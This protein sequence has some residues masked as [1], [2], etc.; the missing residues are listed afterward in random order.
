M[1]LPPPKIAK[2]VALP[3]R[4]AIGLEAH[5]VAVLAKHVKAIA[6]DGRCA[7]RSWSA[8]V[9]L[10]CPHRL[11]PDFLPIRTIERHDH[12]VAAAGA[13]ETLV[14]EG[15]PVE[16][17]RVAIQTL[18]VELDPLV[19]RL[20]IALQENAPE[21]VALPV[22]V[23]EVDPVQSREIGVQLLTLLA[24]FD[25]GAVDFIEANRAAL[26]PLFDDGAWLTFEKLV[27]DYAFAE[28]QAGL[29]R[30]LSGEGKPG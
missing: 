9:R 15:A 11:R 25:P 23:S 18:A 4:G 5:Q 2:D 19:A 1:Q 20:K 29:E 17:I 10:R 6:V 13:L 30:V 28:A 8:I 21:T 24:A 26:R 16:I 14:G 3:E 22:S 7:A 12:A 27:S